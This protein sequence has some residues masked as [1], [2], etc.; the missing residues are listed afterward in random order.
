VAL[1][2]ACQAYVIAH[3]LLSL[4]RHAKLSS[5]LSTKQLTPAQSRQS[6]DANY[7]NTNKYRLIPRYISRS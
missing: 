4:A 3:E 6:C 5:A 2:W 7:V 1:S